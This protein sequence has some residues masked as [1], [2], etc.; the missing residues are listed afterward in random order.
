MRTKPR[1]HTA[2]VHSSMI[3]VMIWHITKAE[4][5]LLGFI[6]VMHSEPSPGNSPDILHINALE[7]IAL[8][9]NIWFALATCHACNPKIQQQHIGNFL[10]N[11]TS[12]LFWMLHTSWAKWPHLHQLACFL[13]V[14]LTYSIIHFQF[15]SHHISGQSNETADLLSH[16]S[17]AESWGSVIRTQPHNLFSCKPYHVQHK[18]LLELLGCI[19]RDQGNV[20]YQNNCTIN[21]R[22]MHFASWLGQASYNDWTVQLIGPTKG[23]MLLEGY[24]HVIMT[25]PPHANAHPNEYCRAPP[26]FYISRQSPYG[27]TWNWGSQYTLSASRL[28]KGFPHS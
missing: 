8:S 12:T 4:L 24:V 2:I 22:V 23:S 26:C 25:V 16:P 13:Q 18:L 15:E 3:L 21:S 1:A 14:F 17:H 9:V 27:C 7:F 6:M 19:V 5:L 10:T 20:H 11:N 28:K